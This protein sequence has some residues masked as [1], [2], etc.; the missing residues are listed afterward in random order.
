MTTT[1]YTYKNVIYKEE[2]LITR[3][4]NELC[5][6]R[7]RKLLQDSGCL[8]AHTKWNHRVLIQS[9]LSIYAQSH[10]LIYQV[11]HISCIVL[12]FLAP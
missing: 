4:E 1:I 10:L 7:D 5:G 9:H 12:I 8:K 6:L 3:F 11:I 2:E